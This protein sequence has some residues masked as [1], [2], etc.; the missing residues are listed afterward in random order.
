MS[1]FNDLLDHVSVAAPCSADWDQMIGNERQRFCGQCN[2]NVYNLS[3]LTKSEAESLIAR[4][5][6]RLCIR[7]YR[8][9]DGS[10]LTENCPVGL[11]AI[12]RRISKIATAMISAVLSL[13]TGLGA[14]EAFSSLNRIGP[15]VMGKLVIRP[16]ASPA[17]NGPPVVIRPTGEPPMG[18]RVVGV[19][20]GQMSVVSDDHKSPP[21]KLSEAER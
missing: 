12:R 11:R 16:N 6:G 14:Y 15:S 21:K 18:R 3:S 10:I 13:L 20:V 4:S 1:R 7:F 19:T 2:L 9:A 17:T 8:R 5:E